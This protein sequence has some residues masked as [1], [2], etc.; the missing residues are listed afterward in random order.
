[1][2]KETIREEEEEE[3]EASKRLYLHLAWDR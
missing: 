2:E 3:E 1:V